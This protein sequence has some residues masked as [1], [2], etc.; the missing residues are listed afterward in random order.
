VSE[1]ALKAWAQALLQPTTAGMTD[2][3]PR[4]RRL[5]FA[6]MMLA[7]GA[8]VVLRYEMDLLNANAWQ[9]VHVLIGLA[10]C[11]LIL[12]AFHGADALRRVRPR[13]WG[14]LGVAVVCFL[15]FWYLGRIDSY[16]RWWRSEVDPSDTFAP[17]YPFMYFSTSS[18][19]LRLVIPFG[20]AWAFM[21]LR[22][23]DL[24]LGGPRHAK[25]ASAGRLW[26]VY[27]L[28][29]I[30]VL[31][32]VLYVAQT[33]PFLAKY[34]LGRS[35]IQGGSIQL[36]HLVVHE[37]FY[38]LIFV[39]GEAF[40]RGFLSFSLERDFGL[41]ALALMIVPYVTAHFGKPL[42][43]TLGAIVAGGVLG[44][45]ALKH[46]SIWLGV[47]VHFGVALTMDLLAI[48]YNGFTIDLP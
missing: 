36:E 7:L 10:S 23:R 34:P 8:Q 25:A 15:A 2:T 4:A 29:F 46:R 41:Y 47:A 33:A 14:L 24:G 32:V 1:G 6:L 28:L 45:L 37:G 22:P 26:P 43:E 19:L 27:L 20:L 31:P 40:W 17:V 12:R 21:G 48:H 35:M 39:S 3:S 13:T 38:L 18:T 42:P 44:W 30:G 9:G 11:L 5:P 16:H